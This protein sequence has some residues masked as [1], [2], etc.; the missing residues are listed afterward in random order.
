MKKT[1]IEDLAVTSGILLILLVIT[2]KSN[3]NYY[4]QV[5]KTQDSLIII[6]KRVN[7]PDLI[8]VKW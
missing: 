5:K 8:L 2:L 7:L 6:W 4:I 1:E 3:N